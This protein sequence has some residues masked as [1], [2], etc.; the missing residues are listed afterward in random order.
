MASFVYDV[1]LNIIFNMV[2]LMGFFELHN[3]HP[4]HINVALK[5]IHD[6]LMKGPFKCYV[7][8]MGVR[9]S[10]FPEKSATKV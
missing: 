3:Q 6:N 9:V 7:T 4:L 8:Q 5:Y 10:T 1:Q 2:T